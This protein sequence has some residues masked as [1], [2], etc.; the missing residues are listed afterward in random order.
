MRTSSAG[1][2]AIAK[3]VQADNCCGMKNGVLFRF[4]LYTLIVFGFMGSLPYWVGE[5]D[6]LIF[7]EN[8]FIQRLQLA[9]LAATSM[10]LFVAA[11]S[12]GTPS[13]CILLGLVT[14]MAFN[15]ELDSFWNK[16]IPVFGWKAMATLFAIFGG[17]VAYTSRST[18][19]YQIKRFLD[20]HARSF[21][22]FWCGFVVVVPVA[23][24]LGHG[25][26]LKELM[27]DDYIHYYKRV[28]EEL[29]ELSGYMLLLFGAL[30]LIQAGRGRCTA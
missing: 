10:L 4:G 19:K 2:I 26:F 15:R 16:I 6:Y 23:Q 8:A 17:A 3:L 29:G 9:L 12:S 11:R 5:G 24:L 28:I 27:G 22:L 7:A 1:P 14:M 18:L 21:G 20:E 13:V 25:D 30:E